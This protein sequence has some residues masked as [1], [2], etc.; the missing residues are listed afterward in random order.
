MMVQ[1]LDIRWPVLV[2]VAGHTSE[3]D[4]SRS[5]SSSMRPAYSL[6]RA[7]RKRSQYKKTPETAEVI[8]R[9]RR[10]ESPH[11]PTCWS[12]DSHHVPA[13]FVL[14][15][16]FHTFIEDLAI[17]QKESHGRFVPI[18]FLWVASQES[19][20]LL[21]QASNLVEV[22][23]GSTYRLR[24]HKFVLVLVHINP[25]V[26]K[27]LSKDVIQ[28]EESHLLALVSFSNRCCDEQ[29]DSRLPL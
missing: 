17:L 16:V 28:C 24:R 11:G 6:N 2:D 27:V 5:F 25:K 3:V 8:D 23:R 22:S 4:E 13:G 9:V 10:I 1:N 18:L 12:T 21:Q 7:A 20:D 29:Y 14:A 15:P 26:I 19:F